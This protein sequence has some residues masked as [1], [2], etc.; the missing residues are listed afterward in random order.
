MIRSVAMLISYS[1]HF[2]FTELGDT[3]TITTGDTFNAAEI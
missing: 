3:T 1:S 2:D